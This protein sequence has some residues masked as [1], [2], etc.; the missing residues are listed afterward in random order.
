M[1]MADIHFFNRPTSP[2]SLPKMERRF[3]RL[4]KLLEEV[5]KKDLEEALVVK[6]NQQV[7]SLNQISS[8]GGKMRKPIRRHHS[9]II[10]L[11]EK[12]AKI[13]PRNYYTSLWMGIGMSAFGI[14][15]GIAFGTAMENMGL[16]GV[17]IPI[18]LGIGLAVGA[19]MDKKAK[20]EGRQLDVD[21]AY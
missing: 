12:E 2:R 13:V 1:A 10:Q 21:W 6:I 16:L 11:L 14:P 18:G 5:R 9:K 15:L 3:A 4:E 8:S 19:G 7:D 20:E 17:G